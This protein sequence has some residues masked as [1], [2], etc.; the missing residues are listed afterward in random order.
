MV[1]STSDVCFFLMLYQYKNPVFLIT[2]RR[3]FLKKDVK[4]NVLPN[5]QLR[6]Q[7]K[8]VFRCGCRRAVLILLMELLDYP[9]FQILNYY[10]E[11]SYFDYKLELLLICH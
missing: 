1:K 6:L 4:I 7:I 2:E 10:F 5:M 9:S 11:Y 3:D 8:R